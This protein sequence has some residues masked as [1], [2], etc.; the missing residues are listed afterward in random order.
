MTGLMAVYVQV[1]GGVPFGAREKPLSINAERLSSTYAWA[2]V[3]Q[4]LSAYA[5]AFVIQCLPIKKKTMVLG[6]TA[7]TCD[8]DCGVL[9]ELC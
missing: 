6:P 3:T 5:R 1:A 7:A 9:G 8:G 4:C 2:F